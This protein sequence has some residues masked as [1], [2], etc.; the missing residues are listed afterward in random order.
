LPQKALTKTLWYPIVKQVGKA[1]G[2]KVTKKGVAKGFAVAIPVLGGVI[3]GGLN[4]AS[5]LPMAR[6]LAFTFDE[7]NFGYTEEKVMADYEEVENLSEG[8]APLEVEKTSF[9]KAGFDTASAGIKSVGNN[10]GSFLSKAK[11]DFSNSG[12]MASDASRIEEDAFEKIEKLSRLKEMGAITQEEFDAKK[13]E[14]LAK[15]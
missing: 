13:A 14:L 9:L 7:A 4:F 6:R 2:I 3:S 1:I 15:I 11:S 12:K 5:L 8:N 10:L